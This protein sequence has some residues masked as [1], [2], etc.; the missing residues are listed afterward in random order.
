MKLLHVAPR[1]GASWVREGLQAFRRAP[2]A[3]F[4]L[5]MLFMSAV[6][7][8]SRVPMVGGALAVALA[9]A[10]TLAL[11]VAAEQASRLAPGRLAADG[12]PA[13]SV[14]LMAA[15]R[16]VRDDIR[17]LAM[18]GALYGA[19]VLLVGLLATALVGDPFQS[20]FDAQ[21][22]PRPE[23][24]QSAAFQ[25]ALLLRMALYLPV[26]LAFWHAPALVH[27]HG[28]PPVKSLFFSVVTCLRNFGA[29]AV[30]GLVWLAVLLAASLALSLVASVAMAAA[31]GLGVAVMVGGSFV[32]TA[33]FLA[34]T[35]FSFRDCFQAD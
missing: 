4:S 32:L 11:M 10:S 19:A 14:L 22:A 25:G 30:F 18:L 12:R 28:V 9:P 23:V 26:A 34:S 3:F 24:V 15:F 17:P 33:M 5:F 35:W 1:T 16:A 27:W 20:A 8:L 2:M 6:A 31:G 21:G 13:S 7:V 29:M